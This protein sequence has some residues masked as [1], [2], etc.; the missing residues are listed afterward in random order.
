MLTTHETVTACAYVR[1]Q[2]ARSHNVGDSICLFRT[3]GNEG[4]KGLVNDG[5]AAM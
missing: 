2:D 5:R 3:D 1:R 4:G